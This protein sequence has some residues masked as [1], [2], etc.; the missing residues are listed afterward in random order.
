[1]SILSIIKKNAGTKLKDYDFNYE[2]KQ[3]S[4]RWIFSREKR[5]VTQYITF[6]KSNLM[7]AIRVEFTTS[8]NPM[9]VLGNHLTGRDDFWYMYNDDESLNK[10]VGD[11]VSIAINEGISCL[12]LMSTPNTKP[13]IEMSKELLVD[14]RRKADSF[15]H[16]YNLDYSNIEESLLKVEA[17]LRNTKN[18]SLEQNINVIIFASAYIGELV[19]EVHNG[20]WDWDGEFNICYLKNVGDTENFICPMLWVT[21]FWSKPEMKIYSL[22]WK[23]LTLKKM[24]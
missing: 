15:A 7:D 24:I 13:T 3:G 16:E 17:I 9:P 14:T 10:V 6:Q 11:L 19:K 5:G 8:I 23:Y 22:V 2:G 18:K 4:A 12:D 1:L 20:Y 21:D